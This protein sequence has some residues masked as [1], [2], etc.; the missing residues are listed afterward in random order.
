MVEDLQWREAGRPLD[1]VR[2]GFGVQGAPGEPCEAGRSVTSSVAA[3]FNVDSESAK[4][5]PPGR[6]SVCLANAVFGRSLSD[7]CGGAYWD[8]APPARI[9]GILVHPEK[10]KTH[11]GESALSSSEP[12]SPRPMEPGV[13]SVH[14]I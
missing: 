11:L 7:L 14:Y 9:P 4:P 2:R 13:L 8:Q 6:S 12:W 1:G 3:D 5:S 10:L